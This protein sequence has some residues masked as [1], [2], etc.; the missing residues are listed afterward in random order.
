MVRRSVKYVTPM[1]RANFDGSY[2]CGG[3]C[4]LT[5]REKK[6][7]AAGSSTPST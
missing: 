7:T 1:S 6:S 2:T 5:V 4:S 3:N